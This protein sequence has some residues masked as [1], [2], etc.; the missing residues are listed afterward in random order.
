[1]GKALFAVLFCED[2]FKSRL[3]L[4]DSEEFGAYFVTDGTTIS[5]LIRRAPRWKLPNGEIV[6]RFSVLPL[7][8][9]KRAK[10][11]LA[12]AKKQHAIPLSPPDEIKKCIAENPNAICIGSDAGAADRFIFLL[13]CVIP[14]S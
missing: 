3:G 8:A 14:F 10:A 4:R 12:W 1:M 6:R 2:F 7:T 5:V 11:L 13:L 9:D